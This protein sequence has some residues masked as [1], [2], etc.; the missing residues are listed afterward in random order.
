MC[1]HGNKDNIINIIPT[2]FGLAFKY[3]CGELEHFTNAG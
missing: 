2:K 1:D 3:K